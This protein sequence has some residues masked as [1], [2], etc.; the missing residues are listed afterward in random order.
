[1]KKLSTGI[2]TF[3]EIIPKPV[4]KLT[5]F[6]LRNTEYGLRKFIFSF[7]IN[8]LLGT[9]NYELDYFNFPFSIVHFQFSIT[10]PSPFIQ[11]ANIEAKIN[12]VCS[13]LENGIIYT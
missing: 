4:S 5:Y 10:S 9:W 3:S 6:R 11:L 12:N 1:M 7:P 2:Q 8:I 13:Y